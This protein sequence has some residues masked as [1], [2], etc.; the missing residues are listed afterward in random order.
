MSL[1]GQI[2]FDPDKKLDENTE[3]KMKTLASKK[4]NNLL[5]WGKIYKE[6][7]EKFSLLNGN[8]N[9]D[10]RKKTEINQ[11]LIFVTMLLVKAIK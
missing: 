5:I 9:V 3:V 1:N 10:V 2:L 8:I 4:I 11:L 7:E 6:R